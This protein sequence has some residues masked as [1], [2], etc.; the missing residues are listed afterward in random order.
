MLGPTRVKP[1]AQLIAEL[2]R[3]CG[4]GAAFLR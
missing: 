2:E 1:S 4:E 3:I